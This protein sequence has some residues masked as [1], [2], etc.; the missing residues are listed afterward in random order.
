MEATGA[1]FRVVVF[2]TIIVFRA[3][4]PP[5]T[6]AQSTSAVGG[7]LE[8]PTGARQCQFLSDHRL[9]GSAY[10]G[11]FVWDCQTSR[12]TSYYSGGRFE[13]L[14]S[15]P[16]GR[17]LV[18]G[19]RVYETSD[20]K[21]FRQLTLADDDPPVVESAA[22]SRDGTLLAFG[23]NHGRIIVVETK[24]W[25]VVHRLAGPNP[26]LLGI[27]VAFAEASNQLIAC[28]GTHHANVLVTSHDLDTGST[29]S[30]SATTHGSR[31][32]V[33]EKFSVPVRGLAERCFW[34]AIRLN[35]P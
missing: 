31:P 2:A 23:V 26:K 22:F 17:Y 14:V 33:G 27:W 5:D 30:L 21:L 18:C 19:R 35:L 29:R 16:D 10:N 12:R 24:T 32:H 9:A 6:S 15:S 7:V 13:T 28:W 11:L 4:S 25:N 8:A 1:R 34:S 3:V 20:L